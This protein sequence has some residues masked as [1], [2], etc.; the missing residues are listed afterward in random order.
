MAFEEARAAMEASIGGG[1]VDPNKLGTNTETSSV[2][3]QAPT[4]TNNEIN[5]DKSAS[6][7]EQPA[8][9]SKQLDELLDLSSLG[10]KIKIGEDVYTPEEL[11]KSMLRWSDYTK[12]TQALSVEK[13]QAEQAQRFADN[14]Q[15]DL[16]KVLQDPDKW[17][18]SFRKMYPKS[19]Q[20]VYDKIKDKFSGQSR[21]T[22]YEETE[23]PQ[24]DPR[25]SKL[26]KVIE[27]MDSRLSNYEQQSRQAQLEK[28]EATLDKT[29]TKMKSKYDLGSA[30]AN[31]KLEN[32]VLSRA[33]MMDSDPNESDFEELYKEEYEELLWIAKE[34]GEKQF[35][36]QQSANNQ[37]KD[38]AKGGG[39]PSAAP[40]TPKTF[41]EARAAMEAHLRMKG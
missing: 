33:Q 22:E 17:E 13:K 23:T 39:T 3:P 32:L 25:T 30:K 5:D 8:M 20:A 14:F 10:K 15:F 21:E 36:S 24:M 26:L 29:I 28:A 38:T 41:K 18:S 2:E 4:Q 31:A 7:D 19:Y 34:H 12:K 27:S 16:E 11:K 35:R 40:V 9:D 1:P 6:G 37:A